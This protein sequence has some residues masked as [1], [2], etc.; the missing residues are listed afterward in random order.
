MKRFR[1]NYNDT[2]KGTLCINGKL[3]SSLYDGGFTTVKE[4]K[5]SLLRKANFF[6]VIKTLDFSITTLDKEICKIYSK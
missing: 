2:I 4:I 6:G 3:V 1:V 5:D